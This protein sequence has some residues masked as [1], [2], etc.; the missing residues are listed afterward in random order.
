MQQYSTA[1]LG[2]LQLV[3]LNFNPRKPE[4]ASEWQMEK[5]TNEQ[6]KPYC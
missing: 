1:A 5:Q 6:T 2:E 3:E 4:S